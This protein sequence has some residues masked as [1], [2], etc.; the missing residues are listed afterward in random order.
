MGKLEV[1]R[2]LDSLLKLC[3]GKLEILNALDK[4]TTTSDS[5]DMHDQIVSMYEGIKAV[6]EASQSAELVI[7]DHVTTIIEHI[8]LTGEL[9]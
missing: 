6:R 3:E 7:P 8:Q 4:D 9:T 2:E 5:Y 1:I